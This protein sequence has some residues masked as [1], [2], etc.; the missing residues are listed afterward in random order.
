MK[1]V[2]CTTAGCRNEGVP[3]EVPYD[4]DSTVVCGV[5]GEPIKDIE[6]EYDDENVEVPP[7]LI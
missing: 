5:C 4:P 7:W 3:I 2:T 1:I 6:D